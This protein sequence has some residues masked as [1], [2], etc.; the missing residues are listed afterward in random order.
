MNA[1]HPIQKKAAQFTHH[2]KYSDCE[3]EAHVRTLSRLC[4]HFKADSGERAWKAIPDRL[5]WPNYLN[6]VEL[7]RN[8]RDREQGKDIGKYSFLNS[9]FKKCNQLHAKELGAYRCKP[10]IFRKIVMITIINREK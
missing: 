10:K 6:R 9:A 1:L 4:A 7:C 2:M 8:I 3:S 5:P